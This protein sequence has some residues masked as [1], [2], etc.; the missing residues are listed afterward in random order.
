MRLKA[1]Q[2]A[3]YAACWPRRPL[4]TFTH[5][6]RYRIEDAVP[7]IECP[8]LVVRGTRDPLVSGDWAAELVSRARDG[9]LA[10]IPGGVHAMT[11]ENPIELAR[12][13][14]FFF[15]DLDRAREFRQDGG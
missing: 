11:Y 14:E 4:H 9:E 1:I 2:V 6:M 8:V 7:E 10:V 13:V 3:D 5:A 15:C 12:V